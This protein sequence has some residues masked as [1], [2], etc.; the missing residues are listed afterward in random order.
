MSQAERIKTAL[1]LQIVSGQLKPGTKLDETEIAAAHGVSRTPVREALM[2][3]EAIG[4]VER[5]K[6]QSS[7]VRGVTLLRIVQMMEVLGGLEGLAGGLAAKRIKANQKESLLK[8]LEI[9]AATAEANNP[10]AYYNANIELHQVIYTASH[11]DVLIEQ[12]TYFGER[13]APFIRQQ[14]HK[15][16]WIEKTMADHRLIVEDILGGRSKEVEELMRRH[17]YF[18]S[19]QFMDIATALE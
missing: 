12:V 18:D 8:A 15:P 4:L 11:N 3:L 19:E 5:R 10:D 9:C 17:V 6:R 14:H 2:K 7:I 1:E 16:G 13:L